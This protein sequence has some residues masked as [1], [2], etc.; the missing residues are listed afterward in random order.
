MFLHHTCISCILGHD[1]LQKTSCDVTNP[2]RTLN[3]LMSV[4]GKF[5][6]TFPLQQLIV[7]TSF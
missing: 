2:T 4:L 3:V 6:E 1:W 7:K 5:K